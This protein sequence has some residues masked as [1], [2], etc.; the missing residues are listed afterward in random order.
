MLNMNA[1]I[2]ST[3]AMLFVIT[4][5]TE[6]VKSATVVVGKIDMLLLSLSLSL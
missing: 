4:A 2:P 5:V 6:A 1:R 3:T